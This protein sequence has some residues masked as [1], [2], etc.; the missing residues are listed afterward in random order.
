MTLAQGPV[1]AKGRMH[2]RHDVVLVLGVDRDKMRWEVDVLEGEEVARQLHHVVLVVA[3]GVLD[4]GGA[5]GRGGIVGIVRTLGRERRGRRMAE[6]FELVDEVGEVHVD[7][8]G[9]G[10]FGHSDVSLVS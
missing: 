3:G 10:V 2:I 7:I 4:V 1:D 9:G 6:I 5:G 8:G